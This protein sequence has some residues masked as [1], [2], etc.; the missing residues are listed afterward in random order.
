VFVSGNE[1]CFLLLAVGGGGGGGGGGGIRWWWEMLLLSA[2]VW[3]LL[4]TLE[5][6]GVNEVGTASLG[7]LTPSVV[8]PD[9]RR[10]A[11][12]GFE[13]N[14]FDRSARIAN[15]VYTRFHR[16][17]VSFEILTMLLPSASTTDSQ[18]HMRPNLPPATAPGNQNS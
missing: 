12:D 13:S 5:C 4:E 18:V 10:R 8:G 15:Q 1:R 2:A 3:G 11:S 9:R 14:P 17:S 16:Q 7:F 6:L